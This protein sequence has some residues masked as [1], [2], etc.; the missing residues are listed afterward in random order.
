[1]GFVEAHSPTFFISLV[2]LHLPGIEGIKNTSPDEIIG[3]LGDLRGA[4]QATEARF[5][6]LH[7]SRM[8][9]IAKGRERQVLLFRRI[10]PA[11]GL[12]KIQDRVFHVKS[13][14]THCNSFW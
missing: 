12:K 2:S 10:V 14:F 1:I 3:G 5:T 11:M 4:F 8:L 7:Q 6:C 13:A 9:P